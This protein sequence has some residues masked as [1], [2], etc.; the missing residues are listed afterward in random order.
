MGY[1]K[2][3]A[4]TVDWECL[5]HIQEIPPFF[6][7]VIGPSLRTA[8]RCLSVQTSVIARRALPVYYALQVFTI[9]GVVGSKHLVPSVVAV[10]A[11]W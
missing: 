11:G 1:T 6:M 10:V 3:G 7:E 4:S 9:F 8:R 5:R 2:G